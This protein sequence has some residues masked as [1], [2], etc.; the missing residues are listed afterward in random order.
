MSKTRTSKRKIAIGAV[1]AALVLVLVWLGLRFIE[2]RFTKDEQFGD[3]GDWGA[4]SEEDDRLWL[5]FNGVDYYTTDDV[6]AYLLIGTDGSGKG[7][8][9]GYNGQLADFLAVVLIDKTTGKYAFLQLDRDTIAEVYVRDEDG[10][11]VGTIEE[12]ICTAHWYGLDED[13]RNE[14]TVLTVSGLLG[15]L[16]IDGYFT[17][18]MKDIGRVNHA[19]G[20]VVIDF[21]EDLTEIDPAFQKGA[22][23]LLDDKQAEKFIRARMNVGDGTN[24]E[25]MG[26][27]RQYM[28][29]AYNL[30]ISQL[31]ENPDYI[32]DL[33]FE[34]EDVIDSDLTD[35]EVSVIAND[36]CAYR[37][38]GILT[39]TGESKVGRRLDDGL[40]HAEFIVN[41][42]SILGCMRKVVKLEESHEDEE[43]AEE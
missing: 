28:Q 23:V 5:T 33:Y 10:N 15:G 8:A 41:E 1:I 2:G 22:T 6:H 39:F 34:L 16:P 20:G 9:V 11:L 26:R 37:S 42:S 21:D 29:K 24:Q 43:E 19:I 4:G 31:R 13:Q 36:L 14:S 38:Q 12:Q 32:N 35:R 27:Q 17:L 30:V 7:G 3:K 18:N 40:E 25:R